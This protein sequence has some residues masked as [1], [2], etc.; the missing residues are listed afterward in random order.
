LGKARGIIQELE[1]RRKVDGIIVVEDAEGRDSNN[2]QGQI[3]QSLKGLG[4]RP[5]PLRIEVVIAVQMMEAWLLADRRALD[6]V[7]GNQVKVRA[8]PHP[9][10]A[11]NPKAELRKMLSAANIGYTKKIAH[12]IGALRS[13]MG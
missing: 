4:K 12:E 2:L 8:F 6:R 3:K 13:F 11:R 10:K 9:D 1:G 5:N 7:L